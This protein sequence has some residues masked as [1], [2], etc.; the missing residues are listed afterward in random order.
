MN[1]EQQKPVLVAFPMLYVLIRNENKSI[2]SLQLIWN[3][4]YNID[5][6]LIN[7]RAQVL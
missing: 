1:F 6:L 2:F 4:I 7:L 3:L 5:N